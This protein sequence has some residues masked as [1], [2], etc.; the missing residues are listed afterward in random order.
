MIY[1]V[2]VDFLDEYNEK[3]NTNKRFEQLTDEE[4]IELAGIWKFRDWHSFM[5]EFNNDGDFAPFPSDHYI[6]EIK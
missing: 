2:S 3:H 1:I 6:R 5:E 4:V